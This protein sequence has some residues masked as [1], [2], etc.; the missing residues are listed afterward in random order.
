MDVLVDEVSVGNVLVEMCTFSVTSAIT[1]KLSEIIFE[2]YFSS[3]FSKMLNNTDKCGFSN[4]Y[5]VLG[6]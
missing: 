5:H 3:N 2:Q 1:G 4:Q 6:G